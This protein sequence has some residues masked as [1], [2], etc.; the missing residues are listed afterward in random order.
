MNPTATSIVI[1]NYSCHLPE[2]KLSAIRY[3]TNRLSTYPMNEKNK[4]KEYD[5]LKQILYN[6][7]YGTRILNDITRTNAVKEQKEVKNKK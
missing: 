5:T 4:R 7:K 1:P 3:L 6:N 2:Q